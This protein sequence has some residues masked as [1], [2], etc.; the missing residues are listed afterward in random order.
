ML[1]KVMYRDRKFDMVKPE[2][3]NE[4]IS[5]RKIK[6]FKRADGWADVD[7]APLRQSNRSHEEP[8]RRAK[9]G[10]PSQN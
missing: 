9:S 8:E 2:V 6:K 3:L 1:I 4:L 10:T 5:S 7:T